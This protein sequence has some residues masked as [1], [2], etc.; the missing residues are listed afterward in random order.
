M[1]ADRLM[2]W[3][4]EKRARSGRAPGYELLGTVPARSR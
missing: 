4:F 2:V 3:V 1:A